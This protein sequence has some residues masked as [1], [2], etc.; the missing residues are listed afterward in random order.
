MNATTVL[1]SPRRVSP[2]PSATLSTRPIVFVV[3]DDLAMR[4]SLESLIEEGGWRPKMFASAEEFLAHTREPIASCLVLDVGLP[5]LD[6]LELQRRV[7]AR[8]DVPIIFITGRG[9]IPM[10][11]KAIKAGAIE[12]L[13]KPFRPEILL[14]AIRDAIER[15][16]ASLAQEAELQVL[17]DRYETLTARE[18]E[19]MALVVRGHLNKQVAFELGLSEITVKVHR[20]RLMRKMEADSLAELVNMAARLADT[21]AG[22][23]LK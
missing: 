5:D 23:R 13:T 3:D 19:V 22:T 7:A 10:S 1:S 17:R 12:F 2:V 18:Q 11:V 9:D 6:G 16:R 20:G 15:S 4:E 8:P 21:P 14:D